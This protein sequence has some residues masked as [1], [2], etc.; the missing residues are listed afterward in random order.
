MRLALVL[1]VATGCGAGEPPI[2]DA[3][4]TSDATRDA[5]PVD[6]APLDAA[7]VDAASSCQDLRDAWATEIALH[8]ACVVDDDCTLIGG[9]KGWTCECQPF[10]GDCSGDPVNEASYETSA[11]PAIA[12]EWDGRCADLPPDQVDHVCDC[13]PAS[14]VRCDETGTCVAL[15]VTPCF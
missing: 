13:A 6:S 7:P 4:V 11:L 1:A 12:A 10:L 5:P 9:Y 15:D 8:R 2:A 14:G 3:A